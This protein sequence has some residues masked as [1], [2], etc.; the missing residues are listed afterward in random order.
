MKRYVHKPT[1]D[2]VS[3]LYP[4]TVDVPKG[5]KTHAQ[6]AC[7]ERLGRSYYCY[8]P[9]WRTRWHSGRYWTLNSGSPWVINED[10]RWQYVDGRL[11]FKDENDVSMLTVVMLTKP[12]KERS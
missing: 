5:F 2:K 6:K 11:Y 1:L 10:A 9:Q 3:K 7:R 8:A 4:Y 12:R